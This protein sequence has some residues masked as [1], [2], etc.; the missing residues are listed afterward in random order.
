MNEKTRAA[1]RIAVISQTPPPVHGATL[2]TERLLVSLAE[3][4]YPVKL[5]DRRFSR[6]VSEIGAPSV[7]KLFAVAGLAARVLRA[8]LC[9]RPTATIFFATTRP[10][11]F[12]VDWMLSEL[13][14]LSRGRVIL[15]LHSV[16]FRDLAARGRP[17]RWMVRRLFSAPRIRVVCLG[18]SLTADVPA[19]IQ[20]ERIV[21]IPNTPADLPAGLADLGAHPDTSR[22]GEPSVLYLSNFIEGKGADVFARVVG[23][24]RNEHPSARFL[25]A[26]NAGDPGMA[27]RVTDE[28]TAAG[29]QD[30]VE[31][32]GS[33]SGAHKWSTIGSATCLAFTSQLWEAQPL[34]IIE[35]LACGVPVVAFR[36]GGM[37]DLIV[38]GENGFLVEQGD[39]GAFAERVSALCAD[40]ALRA[41]MSAAARASFCERYSAEAFARAW[42]AQLAGGAL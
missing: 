2:M 6:S 14:R 20:R 24:L 17:W 5:V 36:A 15:Y 12:A 16:G 27:A 11:S 32:L 13:L 28:L 19:R 41:R 26:G 7:R 31:L 8:V 29:A 10:G 21:L 34:T 38:D 1:H 30:R 35:A 42:D 22:P 3:T 25:M 9:W 4:G 23:M 40:Q 18:A 39:V 33:V 37:P